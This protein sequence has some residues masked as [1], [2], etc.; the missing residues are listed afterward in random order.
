ML[1]FSC[2]WVSFYLSPLPLFTISKLF[3]IVIQVS[4]LKTTAEMLKSIY[5]ISKASEKS[6]RS[7]LNFLSHQPWLWSNSHSF[8]H[9][10]LQILR[11]LECKLVFSCGHVARVNGCSDCPM[12]VASYNC[13]HKQ[14]EQWQGRGFPNYTKSLI[15]PPKLRSWFSRDLRNYI[16]N[17]RKLLRLLQT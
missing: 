17:S 3:K 6:W 8:I 13:P 4:S 9:F 7:C 15:T 12:S 16:N 14:D 1:I 2:V 5:Q 10:W 11:W